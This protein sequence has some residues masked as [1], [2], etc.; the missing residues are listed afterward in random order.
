MT[1][2]EGHDIATVIED[3]IREKYDMFATIHVEP[4]R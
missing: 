3:L 2:E 4:M 1:I